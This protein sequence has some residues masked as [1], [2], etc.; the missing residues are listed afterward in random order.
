MRNS[1]PRSVV[2]CGCAAAL[3]HAAAR[4]GPLSTGRKLMR[5]WIPAL[6]LGAAML[7]A[8]PAAAQ[9]AAEVRLDAGIPVEDTGEIYEAGV[10]FGLRGSLDIAPTFAV[11]GGY[12]QFNLEVEE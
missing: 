6:A 2:P 8:A 3:R 5:H 10:G 12:S 11:Y 7:G 1:R 9:L 4:G